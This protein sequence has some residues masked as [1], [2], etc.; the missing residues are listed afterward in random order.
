[1]TVPVGRTFLLTTADAI[2]VG[3]EQ[4]TSAREKVLSGRF[5][6]ARALGRM[7]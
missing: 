7:L 6:N 4:H 1:M 5:D 2:G 3:E